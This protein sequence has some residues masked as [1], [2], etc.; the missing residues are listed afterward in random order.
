LIQKEQGRLRSPGASIPSR[1]NS[2]LSHVIAAPGATTT[3]GQLY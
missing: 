1:I 3:L 2:I